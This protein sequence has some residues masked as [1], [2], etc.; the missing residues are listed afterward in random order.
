MRSS[1]PSPGIVFSQE[2]HVQPASELQTPARYAP[3]GITSA[4]M[5][6][7]PGEHALQ[8][9]LPSSTTRESHTPELFS[10][11]GAPLAQISAEA[12]ECAGS[13]GSGLQIR[14]DIDRIDGRSATIQAAL[15]RFNKEAEA[16]LQKRLD[17]FAVS[18]EIS[19]PAQPELLSS[20][21]K[22]AEA[23]RLPAEVLP[24]DEKIPFTDLSQQ[25]E[26]VFEAQSKLFE[27]RLARIAEERFSQAQA[28]AHR[29]VSRL[30]AYLTQAEQTKSS[31]DASLTN[32]SRTSREAA[33]AQTDILEANLAKIANQIA[34]RMDA[35]LGP[36]TSRID[37]YRTQVGEM[38]S[39]L[40][41][42]LTG[43]TR[44]TQDAAQTQ[45][46]AFERNL[47]GVCE[48]TIT[49]AQESLRREITQLRDAAT[50]SLEG[51]IVSLVE[52]V[53]HSE[54]QAETLLAR[55]EDARLQYDSE[56]ERVQ[57]GIRELTQQEMSSAIDI[58]KDRTTKEIEA[59]AVTTSQEIR[60]RV[61]NEAAAAINEFVETGCHAR[62]QEALRDAYEKSEQELIAKFQ[63]MSS[64]TQQLTFD[65]LRTRSQELGSEIIG[66]IRNTSDEHLEQAVSALQDQLQTQTAQLRESG[67][68]LGRSI[69]ENLEEQLQ[70]WSKAQLESFQQQAGNVL[71]DLLSQM[72]AESEAIAQNLHDRLNSETDL[73]QAKVIDTLQGKL[74]RVN[75]EFRSMI[76]GVFA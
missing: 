45:G 6:L 60:A 34:S 28:N 62:V 64:R 73:W 54:S 4:D 22:H 3:G 44:R 11:E 15:D 8:A 67:E 66:Q 75:E 37:G 20:P 63:N 26:Q 42:T 7:P 68:Q 12:F 1:N 41:L 57:R 61:H 43:F 21:A 70:S 18:G 72:R 58:L 46:L 55:V 48:Q 56:L 2:D 50:H 17:S 76:E 49:Q 31:I 25:C 51:Q 16:T 29:L 39:A 69:E 36:L 9:P 27:E 65:Q 24:P 14:A 74:R 35:V 32:L 47:T 30:E 5:D 53:R 13:N 40:E 19:S 71:T 38:N 33:D 59:L 23:N 10:S 52:R